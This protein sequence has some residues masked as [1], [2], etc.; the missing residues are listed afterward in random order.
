MEFDFTKAAEVESIDVVPEQFR[1]AYIESDGKYV[2]SDSAKG[3]AEAISGLNKALK[4]ERRAT[5]Q[6][7][8]AGEGA[9]AWLELGESPD[10]VKAQ[11][12]EMQEQVAKASD[13]KINLEKMK[14]DMDKRI[15][16]AVGAKD[17]E[18]QTMRRSLEEHMVKSAAASALAEHKGSVDLL[19]PHVL[20]RA[21]V[22]QDGGGYTVRV[23]DDAG[24]AR[25]D[26]KGGF[27]GVAELVKEMKE[28]PTFG[29]AF[30]ASGTGGGG[31][32]PGSSGR[33]TPSRPNEPV[34]PMQRIRAGLQK[35][36]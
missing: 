34:T 35:R 13:G 33:G 5:E 11:I 21:R 1:G 3:L 24:D 23:F 18:I 25:G 14:A 6:A 19:L 17:G 4:N 16:D 10:A 31:A 27:M 29:R 26:G 8:A 15:A 9:K 20:S 28:S 2:L 22:V 12:Q 7:K 30:E 36:T 32:R